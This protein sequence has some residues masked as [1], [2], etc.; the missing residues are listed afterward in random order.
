[1]EKVQQM[2]FECAHLR[3]GTDGRFEELPIEQQL[4]HVMTKA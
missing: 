2:D 1:M 4:E 3:I